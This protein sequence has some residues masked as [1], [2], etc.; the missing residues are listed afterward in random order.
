MSTYTGVTNCQKQSGFL[1]HPVYLLVV[2]IFADADLFNYSLF[3]VYY[4]TARFFLNG[5]ASH[6]LFTF[7][8][9]S[10]NGCHVVEIKQMA[11]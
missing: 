6:A 5:K 7:H 2:Q 8:D 11:R 4:F 1:A 3:C 10:V 9:F